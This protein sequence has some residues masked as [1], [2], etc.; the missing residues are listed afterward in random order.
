KDD[1]RKRLHEHMHGQIACKSAIKA[2]DSLSSTMMSQII[3]DLAK[4]DNRHMCVHGRPTTWRIERREL[5]KRF[6]RS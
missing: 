1:F 3:E 6:R 2:G 5:E 4:S